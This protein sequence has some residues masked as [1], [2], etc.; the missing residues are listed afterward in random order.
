MEAK[1]LQTSDATGE[2]NGGSLVPPSLRYGNLIAKRRKP[3]VSMLRPLFRLI[4]NA[5]QD[6]GYRQN[7]MILRRG[8][9]FFR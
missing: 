6:V 9:Y 8:V 2:T 7:N 1:P 4:R 3:D 5:S